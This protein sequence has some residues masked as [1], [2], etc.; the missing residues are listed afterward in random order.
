MREAYS[1]ARQAWLP[2]LTKKEGRKFIAIRDIA[3]ED[4]LRI[5][6]GRADCDISVTEFLIGLHAISM[7]PE[8]ERD[9]TKRFHN[10]PSAEEI[11]DAIAPFAHALMLDGSGPR[12]LQ[13][14]DALQG[15]EVPVSSLLIESP[16][17]NALKENADHFVKR[18][19][20]STMSRPGAA[21]A[22]L[23]LQTSSPAGGAGHR[24]SMRGGGPVTT[25]VV[26][27]L[28]EKPPS[29]WQIL[30]ANTPLGF[31]LHPAEIAKAMPWLAPTRTSNKGDPGEMTTPEH[32]DAIHPAQAFFG[33]PRRIRLNFRENTRGE[34]CGLLGLVDEF[35]V[36]T[37]VTRPYG[38]NYTNWRHPLSP[39]YK[40]NEKSNEYLPL[41]FKSSTV[42]YKQWIGLSLKEADGLRT[43][44]NTV[45]VF[46][47]DRAANLRIKP[48]DKRHRIGLLACGYAMDNM[49][50]LDFT[51]AIL[52]LI[53]TGDK[54]RDGELAS[55]AAA[56]VEA[57]ELAASQLLS[58][59]KLALFKKNPPD[60]SKTPLDAPR[61][62]FW[63][64][65]E[66]GFYDRLR[67]AAAA[68][69]ASG[70]A[71]D[72]AREDWLPI[73]RKAALRIFDE[74]AP[75]DS[76]EDPDI[77]YIVEA[78]RFLNMAFSGYGPAGKKIFEALGLKVPESK[79]AKGKAA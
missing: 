78:R 45:S 18:G 39:Y 27:R 20:M 65:T 5:D 69:D 30:W 22:L 55:C 32:R 9:W 48:G 77:K 52:P 59:L 4:I 60:N 62:R 53:S 74:T 71:F 41:H 42:N 10:P 66:A 31:K 61:A 36:E 40:P 47:T 43:P 2:V 23:T 19:H 16:G 25:L 56:M 46:M 29:L 33:M 26:P 8:E 28:S 21:I 6:T 49:K 13:D 68:N 7:A 15:E 72:Q 58:A 14:F 79:K 24:T 67:E 1:L 50:P 35:V 51:E 34:P 73:I 63:A 76:P 70:A 64:E 12:F 3:R 11:D 44:A 17:A 75:V 57:A 54:V 37:Y 38:V